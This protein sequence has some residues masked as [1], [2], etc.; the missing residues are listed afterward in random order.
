MGRSNW[1]GRAQHFLHLKVIPARRKSQA[2]GHKQIHA[3]APGHGVANAQEAPTHGRRQ[4]VEETIEDIRRRHERSGWVNEQ[5]S[6][7]GEKTVR[8]AISRGWIN[9][10]SAETSAR[11]GPIMYHAGLARLHD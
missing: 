10:Q 3:R 1:A 5:Y 4:T 2:D 9:G 7:D 6:T 8:V 11:L